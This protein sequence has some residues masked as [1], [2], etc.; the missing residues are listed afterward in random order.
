MGSQRQPILPRTGQNDLGVRSAGFTLIEMLIVVSIVA[1]LVSIAIPH[2][3]ISLLKAKEA[4]L[5]NNLSSMR[6]VIEQFTL[7]KQRPPGSLEELVSEGY[8]RLIPNDITG[9][10]DTWVID[11]SDLLLSAD[12]TGSGISDVHSGSAALATDGTSYNTW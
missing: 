6:Q 11:T 7:D 2:Y 10:A 12:Q 5:R 3:Q 4:V 9:T 8:L 1:L